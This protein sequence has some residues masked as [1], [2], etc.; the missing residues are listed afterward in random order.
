MVIL[1]GHLSPKG[2]PWPHNFFHNRK[3]EAHFYALSHKLTLKAE[4]GSE[5]ATSNGSVPSGMYKLKVRE[6]ITR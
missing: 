3:T 1:F 5:E 6:Y 4:T 2:G